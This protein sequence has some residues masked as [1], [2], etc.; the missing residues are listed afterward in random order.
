M[1]RLDNRTGSK[2]LARYFPAFG[3]TPLLTK[4]DFGDADFFGLG[5]KG[6]VSIAVERKRISDLIDSME[7]KRLSG[8]QLPGLGENY[9][10]AY[11]VVEGIWR[12]GKDG[13]VEQLAGK[14]RWIG[15]GILA[16]AVQNY[17]M[18]LSLRAGLL[19][20]Q[21]SDE[22]ETVEFIVSQYHMWQKPW[23]QHKAHDQ[24]YA[25]ANGERGRGLMVRRREVTETEKMYMQIEGVETKAREL[26]KEFKDMGDL[27]GAEAAKE[28]LHELGWDGWLEEDRK[29]RKKR[30]LGVQGIGA[31]LAER[32]L[33]RV[34]G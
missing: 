25:P 16:R 11:L 15:M 2:E 6:T 21:T 20:W 17:L 4:L 18:G 26:V 23:A 13:V 30:L 7:K 12:T 33:E 28:K 9:D 32:I 27:T 22:R 19:V 29:R 10:Y 24:V 8:H 31:V 3:I 14:G 1:I 5:P 34:G